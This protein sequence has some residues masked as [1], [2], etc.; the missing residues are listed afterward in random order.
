MNT[1][2]GVVNAAWQLGGDVELL[3]SVA[4]Q[5]EVLG[6]VEA[7][8]RNNQP[9]DVK[10]ILGPDYAVRQNTRTAA[11]AGTAI[12]I[13]KGAGVTGAWWQ[14]F[15]M[16]RGNGAV[17]A[18]YLKQLIVR[19]GSGPVRLGV[20]HLALESSGMHEE[21]IRACKAF[22]ERSRAAM[23]RAHR[24]G[25]PLPRWLLLADGN[26]SHESIGK[27]LHA[28]FSCGADVMGAWWSTGW[29]NAECLTRPWPNTDHHVLTLHRT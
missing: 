8:T 20:A 27:K 19:D 6:I 29:G 9:L 25:R 21:G 11:T 16:N 14:S 28:P 3:R 1:R 23:T 15:L 17:Q 12:A 18:R 26:E 2:Y 5:H 4:A 10:A 22:V 24:Q 7:R 13:R